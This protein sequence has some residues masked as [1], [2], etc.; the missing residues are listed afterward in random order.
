[1]YL[2]IFHFEI[3]DCEWWKKSCEFMWK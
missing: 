3:V 1:M 2:K